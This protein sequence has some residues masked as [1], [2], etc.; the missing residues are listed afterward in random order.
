VSKYV[1][2]IAPLLP[3]AAAQIGDMDP[4]SAYTFEEN[5]DGTTRAVLSANAVVATTALPAIATGM[6]YAVEAVPYVISKGA[7]AIGG[8]GVA[9]EYQAASKGQCKP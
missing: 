2:P 8:Y 7:D 4:N 1:A 3:G 5:P 6:A 9:Q